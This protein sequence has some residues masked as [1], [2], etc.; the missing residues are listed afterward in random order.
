MAR[1][2]PNFFNFGIKPKYRVYSQQWKCGCD[3]N[4]N[5]PWTSVCFDKLSQRVTE[6]FCDWS[7]S[8]MSPSASP[9]SNF[10][11]IQ[12]EIREVA[13]PCAYFA[14]CETETGCRMWK[15][16]FMHSLLLFR[17]PEGT[18]K[19]PQQSC[20][21]IFCWTSTTESGTLLIMLWWH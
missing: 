17:I 10:N 18:E 7:S 8:T 16:S 19:R 20:Y 4:V 13:D 6:R 5:Q 12:S 3:W 15:I 1:M 11:G 9:H 14:C 2:C 21:N